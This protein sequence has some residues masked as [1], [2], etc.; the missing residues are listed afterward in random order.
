MLINHLDGEIALRGENVGIKFMRKFYP[1]YISGIQNASKVR[2]V[3]VREESYNNI[4]KILKDFVHQS[5]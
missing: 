3:L 5:L 2:A 4:I 1:F